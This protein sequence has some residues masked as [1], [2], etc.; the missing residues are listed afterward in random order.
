MMQHSRKYVWSSHENKAM[1]SNS[2]RRGGRAKISRNWVIYL[3]L[4][5]FISLVYLV[6]HLNQK[7]LS[8]SAKIKMAPPAPN[9]MHTIT[10]SIRQQ[11]KQD[12]RKSYTNNT[13]RPGLIPQVKGELVL[14][15]KYLDYLRSLSPFP[16][17]LHILFPHKD[18]Y[19][20]QPPV[21]FVENGILRFMKLNPQ[22]NVYVYDDSDMDQV[23]RRAGDDG[24][25]SI[26]EVN[27]LVG[28]ET[29]PAAHRKFFDGHM[30]LP[31]VVTFHTDAYSYIPFRQP[32]NALI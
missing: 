28:T 27:I 14:N 26:D 23:I 1:A 18:Y 6:A 24:I 7:L 4:A 15:Q 25:I 19:K 5:T 3:L 16:K 22:W 31:L 29:N 12:E 8:S 32:S 21:P 10:D 11:R 13:K 17:T 2:D 30:T 9:N 20:R